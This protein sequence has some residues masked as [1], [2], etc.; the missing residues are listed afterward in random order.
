MPPEQML[1]SRVDLYYVIGYVGNA[2]SFWRDQ[3]TR[4]A[5]GLE[6]FLAESKTI[7]READQLVSDN[8]APETKLRKLYERA[9]QIR[10]LSYEPTKT[11]QEEKRENL[12]DNKSV[13]DILKHGYA[14]ANEINLLFVALARAAGFAAAPV[15][16][17]DRRRNAF[18]SNRLDSSQLDAMVVWVRVGSKD[19]YFDPASRYCPFNLVPWFET[20]TVGI[21]IDRDSPGLVQIPGTR[22]E[23][24]VLERKGSF[25]V[26]GD[27]NLL[28]N[29]HVRFTGQEALD[30]RLENSQSDEVG[31]RKDLEDEVKGWLPAGSAVE[32]K[33]VSN[34]EQSG[35]TLDADFALKVSGFATSTGRRLLLPSGIFQSSERHAFQS[36]KRVHPVY[37]SYPYQQVDEITLHLPPGKK[38]ESLPKPRTEDVSFATYEAT[39]R[40]QGDTVE[41]K[42]KMVMNGI[43]FKTDYYPLLRKFFNSVRAG[44][45]QQIVL[46]NATTAQ[47][48]QHK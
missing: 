31:R 6:K 19:Y 9:Q 3:A 10:Y 16:V 8:D 35:E 36:A 33:D 45:E 13:A 28:G 47:A 26:D 34:W 5:E 1:K 2:Q 20:D 44:D 17:V 48:P 7:T 22:T 43:Y 24:A 25:E 21:R 14:S 4:E 11:Q 37:F 41:L 23:E 39:G 27:G 46:E 42:R 12:K 40:S 38:V 32:L 15:R 18:S 29:V 30:R